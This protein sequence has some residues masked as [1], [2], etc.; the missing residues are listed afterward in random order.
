MAS[1]KHLSYEEAVEQL[2]SMIDALEDGEVPLKDLVTKFEE[3][4]KLLKL[5]RDHLKEAELKIEQLNTETGELDDI[6]EES[7]Y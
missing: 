2:E 1:N 3:G 4:S 7:D 5:C 6:S